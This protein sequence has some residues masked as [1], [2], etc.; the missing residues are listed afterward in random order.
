MA[1]SCSPS[2][3]IWWLFKMGPFP[4]LSGD[5]VDKNQPTRWVM[6]YPGIAVYEVRSL[7]LP[8]LRA[9][10]RCPA[11]IAVRQPCYLL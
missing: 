3:I 7:I 8:S 1:A 6:H 11:A 4:L 9:E 10:L 2:W 5:S